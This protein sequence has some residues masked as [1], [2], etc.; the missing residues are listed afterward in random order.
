[1]IGL[2]SGRPVLQLEDLAAILRA[3][4]PTSRDRPL[5]GCTIDPP[6]EG[7]A[8]LVEFQKSVPR[9]VSTQQRA[10]VAAAMAKGVADSLGLA[11]IRVFGVSGR[12]HFAQV[13]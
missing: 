3:F 13:L 6:A 2:R 11:Q 9:S 5:L 12:T 4:P 10:S 8:K 1:A 7:L